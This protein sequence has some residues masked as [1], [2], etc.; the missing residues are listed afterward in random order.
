M[1]L[2]RL[3]SG[4]RVTAPHCLIC[5]LFGFFGERLRDAVYCDIYDGGLQ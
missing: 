5:P 3:D 4:I 1:D 2:G